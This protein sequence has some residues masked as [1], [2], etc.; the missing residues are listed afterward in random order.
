MCVHMHVTHMHTPEYKQGPVFI[1]R[2]V[3][4]LSISIYKLIF[5][6]LI[7]C[8]TNVVRR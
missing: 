1:F 2:V 4:Y 6:P 8:D 7:Q 3:V 5:V